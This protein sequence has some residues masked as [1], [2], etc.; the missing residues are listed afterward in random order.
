MSL[1][2]IDLWLLFRLNQINA[3]RRLAG[4]VFLY[5]GSNRLL[6]ESPVFLPLVALW[7]AP[8]FKPMRSRALLGIIGTCLATVL[9]VG[10]QYYVHSHTRP[11]L[12]PALHLQ[13][14]DKKST[15]HWDHTESFPSDTVTLLVGFS[16]VV[17]LQSRLAG[18]IALLWSV[19]VVGGTRVAMGW[20]YPSDILGGFCLG[21]ICVLVL[22]SMRS[23]TVRVDRLLLLCEPR[24]YIVDAV[25]F[26]FLADA[27]SMFAGIHGVLHWTLAAFGHRAAP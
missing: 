9:S 11:F 4:S 7:F 3:S 21:I 5:F 14:V 19:L 16:T 25:L 27:Y 13:R 1:H 15:E 26:M 23:V 20:H 22:W 24:I 6:S 8:A 18:A 2:G 17:F 12:D 10:S